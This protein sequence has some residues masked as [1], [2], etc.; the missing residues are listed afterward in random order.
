MRRRHFLGTLAVPSTSAAL[1]AASEWNWTF[2]YSL[3]GESE[4]NRDRRTWQQRQTPP[5]ARDRPGTRRLRSRSGCAPLPR[6]RES[7]GVSGMVAGGG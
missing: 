5:A 6:P 2:Q 4:A 3:W 7:A 1:G